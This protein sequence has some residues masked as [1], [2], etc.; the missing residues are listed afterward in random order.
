MLKSD[1]QSRQLRK[2]VKSQTG[3]LIADLMKGRA[4]KRNPSG[5]L[6]CTSFEDVC[7]N[8]PVKRSVRQAA[9]ASGAVAEVVGLGMVTVASVV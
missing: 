5:S 4:H 3:G 6:M 8:S 1:L 9:A 7:N 2:A